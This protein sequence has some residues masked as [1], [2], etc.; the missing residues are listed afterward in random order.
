MHKRT[1]AIGG[2]LRSLEALTAAAQEVE[3]GSEAVTALVD[4]FSSW[5]HL[6][7]DEK[8][9]L[10]RAFGIR[11]GIDRIGQG[12]RSVAHVAHV[13][14][15]SLRDVVV[16]NYRPRLAGVP[17]VVPPPAQ[18]GYG[19]RAAPARPREYNMPESWTIAPG[20]EIVP[21]E[22][23]ARYGGRGQGEIGPSARSPK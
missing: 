15:G 18:G 8:R 6:S 7:R 4:V 14:I 21:R 1:E 12:R 5:S 20:S 16:Y 9:R 2:E 22:F 19:T 3:I 13:R 23:H 11:V 17:L 10:L